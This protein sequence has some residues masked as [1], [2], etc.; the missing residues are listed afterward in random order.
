MEPH[1]RYVGYSV[2]EIVMERLDIVDRLNVPF[3]R[4]E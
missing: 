3:Q 4:T 1:N 2:Y